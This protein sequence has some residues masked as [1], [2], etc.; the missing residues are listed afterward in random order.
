MLGG[1]LHEIRAKSYGRLTLNEPVPLST[2]GALISFL[3]G[4]GKDS[5]A[6]VFRPVIFV[7]DTFKRKWGLKLLACY[8]LK[9]DEASRDF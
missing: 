8:K 3:C 4:L 7:N 6:L 2:C 1:P 9:K 5:R